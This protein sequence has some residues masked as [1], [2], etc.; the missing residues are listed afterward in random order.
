MKLTL[1]VIGVIVFYA[2]ANTLYSAALS[3]G[4]L[5]PRISHFTTPLFFIVSL[6]Y[7]VKYLY[8]LIFYRTAIHI[9]ESFIAL[10]KDMKREKISWR[11]V[12]GA[13]VVEEV[14]TFGEDIC[15]SWHLRLVAPDNTEII[16]YC[17][18]AHDIDP[19]A[20]KASISLFA[21]TELLP[22]PVEPAQIQEQATRR[23]SYGP[24]RR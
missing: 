19:N 24:P 2:K 7:A 16:K 8:Q 21:K 14:E 6:G 20:L 17:I 23:K 10:A 12:A 9:D 13:Q 5:R 3:S 22:N 15:T 4:E 18:S 11:D 1:S